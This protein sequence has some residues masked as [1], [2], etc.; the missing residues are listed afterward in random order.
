MHRILLLTLTVKLEHRR[1]RA[2]RIMLLSPYRV[3][4][5]SELFRR[6]GRSPVV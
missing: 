2:S 4:P 1:P 6:S 3:R 5:I